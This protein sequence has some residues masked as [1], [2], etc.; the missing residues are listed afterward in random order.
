MN[1]KKQQHLQKL[2]HGLVHPSCFAETKYETEE[3]NHPN[4]SFSPQIMP[5]STVDQYETG[6]KKRF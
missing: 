5:I 6:G 4:S 2:V 1:R 3:T